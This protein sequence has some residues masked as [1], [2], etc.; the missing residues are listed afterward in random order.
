[1]LGMVVSL[2]TF[3]LFISYFLLRGKRRLLD[4][5]QKLYL[6]FL[7]KLERVGLTRY[8]HEGPLD[9][10]LRATR[11]LPARAAEIEAITKA[12]TGMRYRSNISAETLAAFKRMIQAFKTR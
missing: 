1:V 7:R 4:P 3:G 10:S 6:Q 9:F 8:A 5:A 12:Y 11:R 2:A